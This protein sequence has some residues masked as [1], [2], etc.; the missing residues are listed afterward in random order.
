[1]AKEQ[2]TA[3]K[4][5]V[6][7]SGSSGS[8]EALS[9][10]LPNLDKT[11]SIPIVIVLHRSPNTDSGLTDLLSSKTVLQVKEADEKDRLQP[12][13]IYLAP[14]DY[15]LLIEED[16]TISLDASSKVN[17]SR[18]SIDVSFSS[19]AEVY[20]DGLTA[21]LLSGANSDGSNGMKTVQQYGGRNIVQDPAEAMV[22]YMPQQAILFSGATEMLTASSIGKVLNEISKMR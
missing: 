20:R 12:G 19:A 13:W 1:M 21:V 6:I 4:K 18:P 7:I 22:S 8:L 14:P 2:V 15:H 11:F 10:I 5:L 9:A 16:G 17:Y 3:A